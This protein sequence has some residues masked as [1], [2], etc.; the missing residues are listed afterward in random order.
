MRWHDPS[1]APTLDSGEAH[2]WLIRDAEPLPTWVCDTDCL[3]ESE[4]TRAANI[5]HPLAHAQFV[6]GR[7]VLRSALA[8]WLKRA[9]A[10]IAI[11]LTADGK[12][13]IEDTGVHFNMS[14]TAGFALFGIG[15]RPLGVDVET[16][17]PKRDCDGLMR[18][19]FLPA[20]QEQYFRLPPTRHSEAFLRGWTCKEALLK[21]IG[22]GVR[23][24]QNCRVNINPDEPPAVFESPGTDSW[25]LQAGELEPGVAWAVAEEAML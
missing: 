1:T 24:L 25:R 4:R 13:V 16:A 8:H 5:R 3:S 18:R 19:Y 7:I 22:S 15:P 12:P 21:A 6:R 14:H 2:V 20:E 11:R 17:D 9:P 23:D 10:E